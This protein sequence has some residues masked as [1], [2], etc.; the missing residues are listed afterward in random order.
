M[1]KPSDQKS[2]FFPRGRLLVCLSEE[3]GGLERKRERGNYSGRITFTSGP[4]WVSEREGE[5]VREQGL[6]NC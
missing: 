5:R 2:E 3:T 6:C 1:L 4:A